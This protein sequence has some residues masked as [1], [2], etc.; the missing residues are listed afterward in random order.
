MAVTQIPDVFQSTCQK[1][2][3]WLR[4]LEDIAN[5]RDESQAYSVL[6]R[7]CTRCAIG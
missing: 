6:R 1:T 2:Q 4:D 3:E 7:C 5:L